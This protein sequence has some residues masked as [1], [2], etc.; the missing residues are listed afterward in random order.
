MP[1]ARRWHP[2]GRVGRSSAQ[3]TEY[4]GR[5]YASKAEA[6]YARDLDL[7]LAAGEIAAWSA[8]WPIRF[9]APDGR[10]VWTHW[11]DFRIEHT[12]GSV[13]LVEIKGHAEDDWKLKSRVL[14]MVILPGLNA[15]RPTRYSILDRGGEPWRPRR[16]AK[17][18]QKQRT[19][20]FVAPGPSSAPLA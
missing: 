5:A 13:E 12:D 17:L 9:E 2:P 14:E 7:R 4:G 15:A 20:G 8:Q 16:R 1:Q 3:R 11:I 6:R 19:R 18:P 10:R